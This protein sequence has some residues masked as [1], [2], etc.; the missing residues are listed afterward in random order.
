MSQD[1]I[2]TAPAVRQAAISK[3]ERE[4]LQR[5]IRQR[6]KVLKSAA[7]QRS[8]ELLADFE[9]QMGQEYAFDQDEIWKKAVKTVQPLVEKAQAQIAS[10]CRELGIPEQFAPSVAL[11]W[12]A[13]GYGNVIEK[14]RGELRTMA[15][16]RIA[17]I[18]AKARTE[19][20]LSCLQAQEKIALAGLTSDAARLFI[21][22]LPGIETLMPRL[23]FAEVAGE[24]EP[25][26]AEQIVSS[27][28]LRQRRYRERQALRRNGPALR[29]E[30]ADDGDERVDDDEARPGWDV[31]GNEAPSAEAAE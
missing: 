30:S 3:S 19:I 11:A 27:N 23:S 21:E 9:N 5:L 10:R 15:K 1:L 18:E 2:G 13:R 20:E 28:A 14:R 8:A 17:A 29:D 12:H 16:T 4:D 26:I 25:P 6:E 31:W 7:Q 22:K 24:A